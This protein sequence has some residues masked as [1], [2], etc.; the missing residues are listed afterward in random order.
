MPG[1]LIL[2]SCVISWISLLSDDSDRCLTLPW[3]KLHSLCLYWDFN[4]A[5]LCVHSAC[6][7]IEN[8]DLLF[9]AKP[10][11][12]S[13]IIVLMHLHFKPHAAF[14]RCLQHANLS[15]SSASSL[16]LSVLLGIYWTPNMWLE[17]ELSLKS[18]LNSHA[19]IQPSHNPPITYSEF[20]KT[21]F[22]DFIYI[23]IFYSIVIF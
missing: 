7:S 22:Q 21:S 17:C 3:A 19:P 4:K 14:I 23:L 9:T 20:Q 10:L 18:Q 16:A 8:V 15:A 5:S 2:S 11:Q 12:S 13:S 6:W 1:N